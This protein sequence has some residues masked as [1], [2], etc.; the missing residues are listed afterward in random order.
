MMKYTR[1][2][3][4]LLISKQKYTNMSHFPAINVMIIWELISFVTCNNWVWKVRVCSIPDIWPDHL[5]ALSGARQRSE[6]ADLQHTHLVKKIESY[7]DVLNPWFTRLYQIF[8]KCKI[9]TEYV[10][11]FTHPVSWEEGRHLVCNDHQGRWRARSVLK[12]KM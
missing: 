3:P 4:S 9:N 1:V 7:Y 2:S 10:Q 5:W 12:P 8:H 6:G 11:S